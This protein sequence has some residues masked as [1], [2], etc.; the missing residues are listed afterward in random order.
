[1]ELSYALEI[2]NFPNCVQRVRLWVMG[3][4]C[5]NSAEEVRDDDDDDDDDGEAVM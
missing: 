4:L 1:M 2:R 5:R 3:E